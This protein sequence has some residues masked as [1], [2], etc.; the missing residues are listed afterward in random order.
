[1]M[2]GKIVK[3]MAMNNEFTAFSKLISNTNT[4]IQ[5]KSQ[6]RIMH[7]QNLSLIKVVSV[8]WAT[9][10]FGFLVSLFNKSH[11]FCPIISLGAV[12]Q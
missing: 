11:D 1:M 3:T 7:F 4:Q 12:P 2:N 5:K 8:K 9:F 6:T 10:G